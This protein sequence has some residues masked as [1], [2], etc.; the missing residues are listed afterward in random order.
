MTSKTAKGITGGS[1]QMRT[2]KFTTRVAVLV[3]VVLV[4]A[5]AAVA[6]ASARP[7]ATT[8]PD[9]KMMLVSGFGGVASNANP[10]LLQGAQAAAD[11]INKA[12][13]LKGRKITLTGCSTQ[14]STSSGARASRPAPTRSPR[15]RA[16]RRSATSPP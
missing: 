6:G 7:H 10:E 8:G 3:V 14:N 5:L 12:G 13:G 9:F 11:R 4:V 15:P 1:N 2:A 16:S